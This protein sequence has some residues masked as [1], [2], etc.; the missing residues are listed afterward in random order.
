M[1]L[2]PNLTFL[3]LA[4]GFAAGACMAQDQQSS[5]ERF[6]A[7]NEEMT[8]VQPTW[9]GPLI[10]PD[11]RLSQLVRLSL[12][13]SYTATGTRT[14]NYGNDHTLSVIV[15]D[16][17]QI[18]LIA[19]PYIQNHS[20][21]M[22]DGFGDAVTEVKYRITSGNAEHGNFALTALLCQSV[23]TGSN[24]N[25]APTAVY[26]PTLAAGREWGRFDLQTTLGGTMPT[27]KIAAQ[28]RSIEWNVTA[29]A[30]AGAHLWLDVEDNA[31]FNYG[32]P[33]DGKT[34]NFLTPAAFYVLGRK[35][36]HPWHTVLVLGAGMQIATSRFHTYNHNFIP[37]ARI[38]F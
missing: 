8:A 13:N 5:Y 19:P 24:Q 1:K 28:G 37:E 33:F 36:W 3:A 10:E 11:A 17:I 12:S 20:A 15:G 25:G 9:M 18:N 30:R 34:E 27:G 4:G 14:A 35:H 22:R 2:I 23:P 26:Y 32:G 31:A 6:R 21:T 29:Q 38:L 7:H 16:R